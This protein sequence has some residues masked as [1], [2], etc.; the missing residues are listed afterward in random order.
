MKLQTIKDIK[1][2]KG[3]KI[4]LR[5]DF[6][7]PLKKDG[8]IQDDSRIKA[9]IPTIEKLHKLGAKIIII[10]HLGRPKAEITEKLRLN[11]VAKRLEELT[12]IKIQ[13][14][15]TILGK[16]VKTAVENIKEGEIILLENIRFRAEEKK[17]EE[18]FTKE[19]SELGEIFIN[20]AFGT[21][22]RKHASTWGLSQ[23][24]PS[25]AGLLM[26]KE[27][28]ALSPLIEGE[29]EK[30]LTMIFGGAKIDTKIGV[31][32]NF[33]EK[34]DHILIGGGLANTFLYAQG[35]EVGESLCEKDQKNT[36]LSILKQCEK[37]KIQIPT[38]I[39]SA[40]EISEN[41]ESYTRN[42]KETQKN[43]KILDIG[44]Q[45]TENFSKIIKNSKTIIWNGPLGLYEFKA[46]EQGSKSIAIAIA[47]SSA[48]SIIGGGD[49]AD[50]IKRFGINEENYTHIST[51]GGAAI[52]FLSNK[53]LA[54]IEALKR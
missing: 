39:I 54:G 21:A 6:N 29:I 51:G 44:P 5:V 41:T 52:E 19:L 22:H 10:S 25:Y 2:I 17:C 43:E 48:K 50:C 36:A 34:A 37:E 42:I 45:T 4:L 15:N 38:D 7:V 28:N 31:I 32:E 8:T 12:K 46:F 11:N 40:K 18:N 49:T 1:I 20:D 47:E 30:P 9:S 14:T 3:K 26:E 33:L 23:Y 53:K 16:D 13:K 24:L 27:I 35:Y